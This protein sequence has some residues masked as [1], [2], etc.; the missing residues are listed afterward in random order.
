MPVQRQILNDYILQVKTFCLH[1]D[2]IAI[3]VLHYVANTALGGAVYDDE[4]AVALDIAWQAVYL[5]LMGN[6]AQWKGVTVQ[7]IAGTTPSPYQVSN[8]HSNFGTVAGD[9][10]PRQTCGIITKYTAGIGRANRGRLYVAFPAEPD[11]A[12]T[13]V[14]V[15]GY[16]TRLDNLGAVVL[17][18]NTITGGSGGTIKLSPIIWHRATSTYTPVNGR[19][20]NQRWATQ[21]R[22]G[23]YGR[24]NVLP[25]GF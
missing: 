23:S 3:N 24:P 9:L 1:T 16:I 18:N 22:R 12:V 17:V 2:Q 8:A 15:A 19:R 10:M 25:V 7:I 21:R 4:T 20:S 14:P 11:N 6:T 5:P 13:A